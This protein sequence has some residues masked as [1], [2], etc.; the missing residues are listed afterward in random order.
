[1]KHVFFLARIR[2]PILSPGENNWT[3]G[4]PKEL[5]K[6]HSW[7]MLPCHRVARRGY[8]TNKYLTFHAAKWKP[9]QSISTPSPTPR[10]IRRNQD[11]QQKLNQLKNNFQTELAKGRSTSF[12]KDITGSSMSRNIKRVK[13]AGIPQKPRSILSITNPDTNV[14]ICNPRSRQIS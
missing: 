5:R 1:M 7:K 2:N 12:I 13:H 3:R 4:S 11:R 9:V 10:Q 14:C 6:T 8:P